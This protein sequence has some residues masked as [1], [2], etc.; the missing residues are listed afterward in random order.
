[1]AGPRRAQ[2]NRYP[3]LGLETSLPP[4]RPARVFRAWQWP[5]EF[6][7]RYS[8]A[9]VLDSHEVPGRPAV[10]KMDTRSIAVKEH[11]PYNSARESP[12]AKCSRRSEGSGQIHEGVQA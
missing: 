10:V 5:R 9:T 4:S 11:P 2:P 8:G 3:D 1:M 7:A 12:Q 6:V